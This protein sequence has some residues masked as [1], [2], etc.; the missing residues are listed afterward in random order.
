[1]FRVCLWAQ[2]DELSKHISILGSYGVRWETKLFEHNL[3]FKEIKRCCCMKQIVQ[4][5][6]QSKQDGKNR[7]KDLTGEG[8]PAN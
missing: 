6:I 8:S 3:G 7:L 1:M 2:T 4:S 5:K